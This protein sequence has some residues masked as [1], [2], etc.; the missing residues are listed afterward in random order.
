MSLALTGCGGVL[1]PEVSEV[2]TSLAPVA[3]TVETA[4]TEDQSYAAAVTERL[5]R[6]PFEGLPRDD[7]R[8][9]AVRRQVF[10]TRV[11]ELERAGPVLE[12]LTPSTD[13]ERSLVGALQADVRDALATARYNLRWAPADPEAP[14][15]PDVSTDRLVNA[16]ENSSDDVR[17][18]FAGCRIPADV[19]RRKAAYEG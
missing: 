17:S 2:V 1:G 8:R 11:A 16:L 3:C 10:A 12:G 18:A 7:L 13:L 15:P 6:F 14:V 9:P 5:N 19:A 4:N